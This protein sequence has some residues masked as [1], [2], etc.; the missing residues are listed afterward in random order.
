[1]AGPNQ[2]GLATST[3]VSVAWMQLSQV[4]LSK[5]K[6]PIAG[7]G[8]VDFTTGITPQVLDATYAEQKGYISAIA[9]MF[10]DNADN[11]FPIS[12]TMSGTQQRLIVPALSQALLPLISK[13][14]EQI[15]FD[16]PGASVIVK[17]Q[18]LNFRP[19]SPLVWGARSGGGSPSAPFFVSDLTVLN[20]TW[21]N[22]ALVGGNQVLI[23]ANASGQVVTL[24]AS[25]ANVASL[26]LNWGAVAAA[27]TNIEL[28]PGDS[29]TLG[30]PGV[31]DPRAV[32]VFGT[33]G[34][35]IMYGF[36]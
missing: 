22:S 19:G 14:P 6:G 28:G 25:N 21:A 3:N 4:N 18:F 34:D 20:M 8:Q 29:F 27:N 30:R 32:N 15:T 9:G 11:N 13:S 33:A 31:F 7:Y 24:K 2:H 1:M 16:S 36:V 5:D 17:F 26:W 10:I 23:P 35:R 12:I